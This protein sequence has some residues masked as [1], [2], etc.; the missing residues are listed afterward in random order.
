MKRLVTVG[1]LALL[2]GCTTFGART[3]PRARYDYNTAIVRSWD[4]QLL[5]NLVRLKYRDTPLFLEV[6]QI[7]TTYTRRFSAGADAGLGASKV[8]KILGGATKGRTDSESFGSELGLI[9]EERPT[10]T[11]T[12]LQ[13]KKFA[14]QLLTPIG[15]D[16]ILIL[17]Q[18]G[19]SIERVF[20][21]CVQRMNGLHN[22]PS[23]SGPTPGH[24]PVYEDFYS[25]VEALRVLQKELRLELARLDVGDGELNP[26]A[27]IITIDAGVSQQALDALGVANNLL[28][29]GINPP[30]SMTEV[31]S[32][33]GDSGMVQ[34]IT[35]V[36]SDLEDS[37]I[38]LAG[39]S[40]KIVT[41][42]L[43][44]TQRSLL[45]V[46]H[47]LSNGVKVPV[48]HSNIAKPLVTVTK[49]AD[50]ALFD[51]NAEVMDDVMKIRNTSEIE[52][53]EQAFVSVSYRGVRFYIADSDLESKSTFGLLSNLVSLQAMEIA[54]KTGTIK[55]ISIG[56]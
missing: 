22:S 5:L 35:P 4:E 23:A 37:A 47:F 20:K 18:S 34:I 10:I 38:R 48:K 11:Y 45:G 42:P 9:F 16:K 8:S 36:Q 40:R 31:A 29:L 52:E 41:K 25:A 28:V 32:F 24:A 27:F 54:D 39:E 15:H 21:L 3:I 12:P 14:Q 43:Y 17:S 1:L 53:R 46:L 19:W 44:L 49:Q 33:L 30:R 50:G 55:T 2:T 51:W 7:N 6:E 56:G 13:G 26:V